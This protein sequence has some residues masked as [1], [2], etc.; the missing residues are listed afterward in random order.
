[1]DLVSLFGW[2]SLLA[3][4]FCAVVMWGAVPGIIAYAVFKT[5]GISGFR[6]LFSYMKLD[7]PVHRLNPI[8][9]LLFVLMI[10]VLVAMIGNFWILLGLLLVTIPFWAASKPPEN[11]IR[12]L[13]IIMLT[14]W[15]GIAWGQS[16]LNPGFS[17]LDIPGSRILIWPRPLWFMTQSVTVEGFLYGLVQGVRVAAALSAAIGFI[18]TTHPSDIIYALKTFKLPMEVNFMIAVTFR[19]IPLLLE[20]SFL[21]LS[22]ERARGLMLRPE[23][24]NV[25]KFFKDLGRV[26]KTIALAM[27]PIVVEGVR[28]SRQLAVAASLRAFRAYKTRTYYQEI[29]MRRVDII[30]TLTFLTV[31]VLGGVGVML[32]GLGA[33]A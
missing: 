17:R 7:S 28:A 22:A 14:Q 12:L 2:D 29:P 9:K 6:R 26:L 18:F 30:L 8:T 11:R 10:A 3:A 4:I 24:G 15:I 27:F 13:M 33:G 19:S 31:L 21:V 5:V 25:I 32:F 16:F 23:G 20:K 1:M